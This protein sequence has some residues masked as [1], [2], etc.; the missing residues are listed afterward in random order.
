M[1]LAFDRQ[2]AI[3]RQSHMTFANGYRRTQ[4]GP[5]CLLLYALGG[6]FM[7]LG[8]FL[9][10]DPPA[11]WIML[12]VGVLM[13]ALAVSFHH[14]T[15]ED[16]V[17][18]LTIYFGPVQLFRR[19]VRYE[20]ITAVQVDRTTAFEGWGIHLSPRGGWVWNIWGRDCVELK[21][22]NGTLRIGTDDASGL[23]DFLNARLTIDRKDE[24]SSE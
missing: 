16:E 9:R 19:S 14:L 22:R 4:S 1:V 5:W 11:Q 12:P 21:L 24:N 10:N 3:E 13:L 6:I 18:R 15:V 7:T 23:V 20:D 8:L 2:F 17:D